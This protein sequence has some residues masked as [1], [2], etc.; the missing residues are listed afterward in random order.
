MTNSVSAVFDWY[1]NFD[2][3]NDKYVARKGLMRR[4]RGASCFK[5]NKTSSPSSSKRQK[6]VE[7]SDGQIGSDHDKAGD[8]AEVSRKAHI[9][10][11]GIAHTLGRLAMAGRMLSHHCLTCQR[12]A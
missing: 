7:Q 1:E 2:R 11:R 4:V 5:K 12:A 9:H 10:R 8:L 6:K 3:S